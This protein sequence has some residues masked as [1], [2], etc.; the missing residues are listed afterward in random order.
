[1][2]G[3]AGNWHR[4]EARH[5][6]IC[7]E[8]V[9]GESPASPAW[10]CLPLPGNGLRMGASDVLFSPRSFLGGHAAPFHL[11]EGHRVAGRLEVRLR[12]GTA[13][14]LLSAAL[15]RTAGAMPSYCLDWYA[16]SGSRRFLG[17]MVDRMELTARGHSGQCA[18]SLEL[19]ARSEGGG[20]ALDVADFDYS[21]VNPVPFLFHGATVNLGGTTVTGVEE[22]RL[23]ARN[24]L[25]P[26]PLRQG[27]I[28]FPGYGKRKVRLELT[29]L[30]SDAHLEE[31]LRSG[32]E[33]SFSVTLSHP[34]GHEM[35]LDLPRLR[36]EAELPL[37][38]PGRLV[39][40]AARLEAAATGNG[41]EIIWSVNLT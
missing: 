12:P 35:S 39:R 28:S 3:P 33:L 30:A 13:D 31:A 6:R 23:E 29:K 11:S 17:A 40:E 10:T 15:E 32:Q 14:L 7:R 9:W 26:G 21:G 24:S 16:P 25:E 4:S 5:L 1:M 37:A 22:F 36:A 34:D 20:P 38:R 2:T 18:L 27:W 19:L 8:D 41:S